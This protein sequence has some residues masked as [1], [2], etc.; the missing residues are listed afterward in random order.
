MLAE[1]MEKLRGIAGQLETGLQTFDAILENN[2]VA[3]LYAASRG[4]LAALRALH[5]LDAGLL[6]PA[7]KSRIEAMIRSERERRGGR[8]NFNTGF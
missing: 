2:D 7:G 4:M 3:A 5:D 6:P 8:D 1:S